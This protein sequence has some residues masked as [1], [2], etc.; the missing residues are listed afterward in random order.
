MPTSKI[1]KKSTPKKST[2]RDVLV[3][4]QTRGDKTLTARAQTRLDAIAKQEEVKRQQ[5]REML[6]DVIEIAKRYEAVKQDFRLAKYRI[7][8]EVYDKYLEI[9]SSGD[10]RED[11]YG[12]LRQRL[13]EHG[14]KVQKNTPN[15]GLLLRLVLGKSATAS[16]I[17]QYVN[18][19]YAAQEF[20]IKEVDFVDWLQ[21]VTI[22]KAA[23]QLPE[24]RERKK[25]RLERARTLVLRYL[26]WRETHPILTGKKPMLAHTANKYVTRDTHLVVMIGTAVGKMDR[27]SDYADIH[28]SHIMPPNLET[29]IRIIDKWARLLEPQLEKNEADF[30]RLSDAEWVQQME[31]ELWEHDVLEAERYVQRTQLRNFTKRFEDEQEFE[32]NA[33]AFLESRG[34]F[35]GKKKKS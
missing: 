34:G 29:E 15:A 8:G 30:A 13:I 12:E 4:V 31:T 2:A 28:V 24:A 14:F 11:F 20:D 3:Q 6:L 17:N 19:L 18:V 33:R 23:T 25:D 7:I 27:E 26:D 22:T 21:K 9:E 16:S 10:L 35:V 32:D 5:R 1:P